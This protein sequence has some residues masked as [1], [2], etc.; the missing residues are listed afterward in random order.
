MK[1]ASLSEISLKLGINKSK[2]AYYYEI[3]LLKSITKIGRM[4]LFDENETIKKVKKI[5]SEKLKGVK[6]KDIKN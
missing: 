6:L 1:Q 4:N 2:L 5:Q 3:G